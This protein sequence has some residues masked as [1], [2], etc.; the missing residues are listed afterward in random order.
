MKM[1]NPRKMQ[2]LFHHQKKEKMLQL[3][4]REKMVRM[5]K[6]KKR[7]HQKNQ[8]WLKWMVIQMMISQKSKLKR[9]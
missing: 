4:K 7:C 3:K 5:V 6:K 2:K 1:M 9:R 8:L